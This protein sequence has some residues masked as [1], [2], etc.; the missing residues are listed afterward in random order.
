MNI[1]YNIRHKGRITILLIA[2]IF[3]VILSSNTYNDKINQMG[4]LFSEMYSDRL[5]A[6]DY[7]YKFAKTLHKRK[8]QLTNQNMSDPEI[9]EIFKKDKAEILHLLANYEKTELTKNEKIY[10]QEFKKDV[11]VMM[12]LEEKYLNSNTIDLKI[13]LLKLQ[14]KSLD[15]SLMQLDK[16]SEIQVFTGKKLNESSQNIVSFSTLLNQLD[17]ALIIII[18]LIIQVL[19]FTSK[20][21]VPKQSQN[22]YLN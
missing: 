8:Y 12:F 2:V 14:N 1:L 10:F 5:I 17:W 11:L 20:S 3:L 15:H 6:Q 16:L 19:I 9:D 21:S 18:G 13:C 22:Q 4:I 7:I